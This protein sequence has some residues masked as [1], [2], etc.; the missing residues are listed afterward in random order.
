MAEIKDKVI[1]VES[2]KALHDYNKDAYMATSN[3]TGTG[4]LSINRKAST[5]VGTNSVALG[6]GCTASGNRSM[7][8]GSGTKATGAVS[9]AE[10]ENTTASGAGAHA[11]GSNTTASGQCAHTEGYYS[12]ASGENSH[13]EGYHTLASSDNQHVYGK[14]NTEDAN[15]TYVHIVGN[16]TGSSA[17]A[18]SNAHTLDWNG[19]A[20][21]AGDITAEGNMILTANQYGDEL[22]A[23]GV[24]GRIFF[25]KLSE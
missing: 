11:E 9:V 13:A 19:N 12:K 4:S 15:G 21:Y 24:T 17:S 18:R 20:W 8:V 22:P 16:G 6:E 23:A 1:T 25:K 3:P 14:F 5:T 7:A 2:L 10:G